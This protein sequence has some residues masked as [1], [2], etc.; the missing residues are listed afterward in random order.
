MSKFVQEERQKKGGS[1]EEE[2]EVL[3]LNCF[4]IDFFRRVITDPFFFSPPSLLESK[5]PSPAESPK[6]PSELSW[7]NSSPPV[8]FVGGLRFGLFFGEVG[9]GLA[10]D[11]D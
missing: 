11:S 5:K 4:W 9:L 7:E 8:F 6:S 1:R 3:R 10:A 2:M